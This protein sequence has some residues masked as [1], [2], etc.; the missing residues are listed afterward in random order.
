LIAI[1]T[2]EGFFMSAEIIRFIPRPKHDREQTDF[3]TIAFR[4][5]VR[6]DDL[7]IDRVDTAPC[8]YVAP[9]AGET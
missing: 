2:W 7:T 9:D 4:L 8:E 6:P 1:A 5:P 3:P